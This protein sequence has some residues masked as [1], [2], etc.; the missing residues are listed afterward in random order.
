MGCK[1]INGHGHLQLQG[2]PV[3]SRTDRYL[4]ILAQKLMRKFRAYK[5]PVYSNYVSFIIIESWHDLCRSNPLTIFEKQKIDK[6]R[7][8]M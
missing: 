3:F 8:L 7:T 1:T 4:R 6:S 2:V 5:F